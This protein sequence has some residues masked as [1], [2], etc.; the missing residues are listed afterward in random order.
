VL[1]YSGIAIKLFDT[2]VD[3]GAS[4]GAKIIQGA[5][6]M[7]YGYNKLVVNGKVWNVSLSPVNIFC[8]DLMDPIAE[9]C[10]K[11]YE[12]VMKRDCHCIVWK[13]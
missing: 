8:F 12:S 9:E 1:G 7:S 2:C 4:L 6:S 11:Y 10:V 13:S 5:A 3:F